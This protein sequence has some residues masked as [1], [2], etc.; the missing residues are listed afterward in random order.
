[1]SACQGC[2]Q[3]PESLPEYGHIYFWPPLGHTQTKL[4]Q[5]LAD[6]E[7]AVESPGSQCLKIAISSDSLATLRKAIPL[8][9]SKLEIEDTKCLV[10]ALGAEPSLEE[11]SRIVSLATMLGRLDGRWLWE[12]LAERRLTTMFQPIVK[13]DD[14]HNVYAHECLVRGLE[15]DGSLVSPYKLYEAARSAK[16]LFHLDRA[17]RLQHIRASTQQQIES[18]IFINFNPTSIYDPEYCLRTTFAAIRNSGIPADRFV[19][20]VVESDHVEDP[21]RLPR[22]LEFYRNAGFRVALDDLGSGFSSL[23]LL[24]RLKPD[25]VKFDMELIRNIDQDP[26]KSHIVAKLIDVARSVGVTTVV[27]G[28]ETDAEWHWAIEH[29]ADLGQGYLFGKPAPHPR[30]SVQTAV[31]KAISY[32]SDRSLAPR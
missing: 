28:I 10:M 22:I 32:I 8:A 5:A 13:I 17:A 2:E 7:I 26:Y 25:F 31:N 15:T 29:G 20:E 23:N 27:E 11:A 16:M 9:L 3:L 6:H 1:M 14:P 12:M 4:A 30:G 24:S 21:E 18:Q 19:F